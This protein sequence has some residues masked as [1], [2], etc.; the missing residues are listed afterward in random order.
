[1]SESQEMRCK[2]LV[3]VITDYLEGALSPRD[4]LR[5][6]EHLAVCEGCRNYLEQMRAT[7]RVAGAL[8]TDSIPDGLREQLLTAFRDWKQG[9]PT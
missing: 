8:K 4:T 9:R 1:M 5:F 2:D 7:I 3:E 6:E